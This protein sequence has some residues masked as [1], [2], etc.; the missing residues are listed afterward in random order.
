[1]FKTLQNFLYY[2]KS[3]KITNNDILIFKKRN[4][5]KKF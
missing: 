2:F 4:K 1:M 3:K 5:L